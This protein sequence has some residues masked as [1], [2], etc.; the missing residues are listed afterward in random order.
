[1]SSVRR[2]DWHRYFSRLQ[3]EIQKVAEERYEMWL[4]DPAA[5]SLRFK[6]MHYREKGRAC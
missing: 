4:R 3:A 6:R 1:M 5:K 2:R